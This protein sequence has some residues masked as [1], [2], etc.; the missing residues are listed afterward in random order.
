MKRPGL[1]QDRA[2]HSAIE[3]AMI[4]ACLAIGIIV[5]LQSIGTTLKATFVEFNAGFASVTP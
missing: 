3:Y 5:A 2:G 1:L 4:A